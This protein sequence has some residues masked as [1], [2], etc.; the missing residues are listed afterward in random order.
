MYNGSF[1]L[2]PLTLTAPNVSSIPP[3]I[4]KHSIP[5]LVS[6]ISDENLALLL[7]IICYWTSGILFHIIDQY[8]LLEQ[9]R[10]HTPEEVTKRN[11]CTFAEVVRDVIKQHLLQTALGLLLNYFED[12]NTT[13]H[14][15]HD[16]WTW[17]VR[18]G[19]QSSPTKAWLAAFA[20]TYLLPIVKISFAFFILD[21]WQYFLHRAMHQSKWLYKQFHSRHHRLYVPYAIGALYNTALEGVLMDTCG[22]GLAY[23]V[24]GLTTREAIWFFCFSTLKTVDDHCG[25]CIPWDPFQILFPN[26]A[27]YHDIHHQSFGIKTNFSQPFFTFWD[28]VLDTEYHGT[29]GYVQKQKEI[30]AQKYKEWVESRSGSSASEGETEDV[31]KSKDVGKSTGVATSEQV[32]SSR[33]E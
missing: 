13:G 19:G 28:R 32:V 27:V 5:P 9:Y 20:Y 30:T 2:G 11:K 22:A 17:Q 33:V 1:T 26:N 16:I 21:S 4:Y 29:R 12:P 23:M 7:P 3:P 8:E 15:A 25:Y 6:W 14:E 24:S 18:F 10:I 31:G